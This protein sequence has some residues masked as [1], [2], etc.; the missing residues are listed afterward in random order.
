MTP[1]K[2]T[3]TTA[4]TYPCDPTRHGTPCRVQGCHAYDQAAGLEAAY[5]R[6]LVDLDS[7]RLFYFG[8]SSHAGRQGFS[9][10]TGWMKQI[11]SQTGQAIAYLGQL[12]ARHRTL[13]DVVLAILR[14]MNPCASRA[15]WCAKMYQTAGEK[16]R[17][18]YDDVELRSGPEPFRHSECIRPYTRAE[19]LLVLTTLSIISNKFGGGGAVPCHGWAA[20]RLAKELGITLMEVPK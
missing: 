12:T 20:E 18:N 16:M 13:L 9:R 3:Q 7:G 11:D 17:E 15:E 14:T 8:E 6:F 4:E 10:G 5:Q 19:R 2:S 1:R